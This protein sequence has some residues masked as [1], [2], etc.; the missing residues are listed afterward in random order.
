MFKFKM[1]RLYRY[2]LIYVVNVESLSVRVL[3]VKHN[4]QLWQECMET[5]CIIYVN[6]MCRI[7]Y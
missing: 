6:V 3:T 5:I 7:Q 1:E 2:L 4:H